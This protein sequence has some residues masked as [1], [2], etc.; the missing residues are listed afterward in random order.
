M[1]KTRAL[2]FDSKMSKSMWGEAV[3]TAAYLLNR[4]PS[5]TVKTTPVEMWT[6]RKP[7]MKRIKLFGCIAFAK[8]KTPL[9]KLD[10]RSRQLKMVGNA[11]NGYRLWD[12]EKK[13]I[14]ISRDVIFRENIREDSTK[15]VLVNMADERETKDSESQSEQE[16][17]RPEPE[18]DQEEEE[19]EETTD[20]SEY[21]ETKKSKRQRKLPRRKKF[22][23]KDA[24]QE[25]LN[26]QN[27][28]TI[29]F[30]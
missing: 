14:I 8:I 28:A 24:S 12:S 5:K 21:E 23:S 25:S 15:S 17:E 6:K 11:P 10:E 20:E 26:F 29:T 16:E 22:R 4:S 3:Y 9:K 13:R 2:V 30:V 18:T 7:D 1:E 27:G 19:E